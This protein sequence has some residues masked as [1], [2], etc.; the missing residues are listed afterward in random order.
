M[1]HFTTENTKNAEKIN[2]E[3]TRKDTKQRY[4]NQ[5]TNHKYFPI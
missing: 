5:A 4:N 3:W 1:D 2:H